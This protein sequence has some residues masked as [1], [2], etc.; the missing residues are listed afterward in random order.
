[1]KPT[2]YLLAIIITVAI[3]F[4]VFSAQTQC[5]CESISKQ[6][7]SLELA[8]T[9]LEGHV[10]SANDNGVLAD[11]VEQLT[12]LNE[13]LIMVNAAMKDEL[14]NFGSWWEDLASKNSFPGSEEEKQ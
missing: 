10:S 5:E 2:E 7:K 3:V 14:K 4:A 11:K 12:R 9:T 1:M 13:R 6:I 8:Y